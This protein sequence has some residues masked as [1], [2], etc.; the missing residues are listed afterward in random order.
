MPTHF[1]KN[2][3]TMC[4]P[5]AYVLQPPAFWVEGKELRLVNGLRLN[6]CTIK[7]CTNIAYVL[8]RYD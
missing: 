8:N 3:C 5:L 1:T 4:V 7:T 2:C 6:V